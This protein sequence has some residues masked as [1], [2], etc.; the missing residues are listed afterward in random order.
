VSRVATEGCDRLPRVA[1]TA[2][3]N[4]GTSAILRKMKDVCVS[5][6]SLFCACVKVPYDKQ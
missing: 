2:L 4:R 1:T 6:L 3:R 5:P